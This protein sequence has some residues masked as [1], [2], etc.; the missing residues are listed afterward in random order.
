MKFQ[1]ALICI[2]GALLAAPVLAEGTSVADEQSSPSASHYWDDA[3][4]VATEIAARAEQ[5]RNTVDAPPY[6]HGKAPQQQTL[7]PAPAARKAG[8]DDALEIAM[9]Q[10]A[11]YERRGYNESPAVRSP[12]SEYNRS[13]MER[14]VDEHL[15]GLGSLKLQQRS[16]YQM[17]FDYGNARHCHIKNP[18]VCLSVQY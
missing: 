5:E 6:A 14:F 3:S 16:N 2:F 15:H 18:G 12:L 9:A 4:S 7:G 1:S 10:Q 17:R 8:A 13:V 11:D